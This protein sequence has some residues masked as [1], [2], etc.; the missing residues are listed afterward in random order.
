MS[1]VSVSVGVPNPPKLE[2]SGLPKG[3]SL[4]VRWIKQD[5]GGSPILRYLVSYKPVSIQRLSLSFA[6][7]V[8]VLKKNPFVSPS[9]IV[10]P[11]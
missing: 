2:G 4:K 1:V 8:V 3:N 9:F 6:M 5:D 10:L 7:S 11:Q